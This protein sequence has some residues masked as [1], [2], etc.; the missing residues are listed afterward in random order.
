MNF[1]SDFKIVLKLFLIDNIM[2]WV[3]VVVQIVLMVEW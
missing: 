1:G 2:Y 3:H